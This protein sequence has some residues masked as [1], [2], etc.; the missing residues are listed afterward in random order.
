MG[1]GLVALDLL[2][3]VILTLSMANTMARSQS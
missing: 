1:T 3:R 2:V